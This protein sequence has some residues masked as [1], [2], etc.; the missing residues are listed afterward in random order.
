MVV[1]RRKGWPWGDWILIY[2][3]LG[4]YFLF[5]SLTMKTVLIVLIIKARFL[6]AII[7]QT[8]SSTLFSNLHKFS[9]HFR[10]YYVI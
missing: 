4:F 1:G 10:N 7:F 6:L 2:E 3:R 9:T 8:I 5:E